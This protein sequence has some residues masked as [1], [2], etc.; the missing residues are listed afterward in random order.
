MAAELSGGCASVGRG[1]GMDEDEF[2][3]RG[4]W[5]MCVVLEVN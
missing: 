5:D 2:F 4:T 3:L 1:S